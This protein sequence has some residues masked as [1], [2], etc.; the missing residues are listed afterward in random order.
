MLPLALLQLID[1]RAPTGAH[2]HSGGME[3]AVAAGLVEGAADLE[4]FC[5][6]R[7]RTAGRVAA[8]FAA[9]SAHAWR[10]DWPPARWAALD[11]EFSAR[12]PSPAVRA[13]SRAMG[14]G[15]RR[16]VIA[17]APVQATRL[18]AAWALCGPP[19]PHHPLVLG[20]AAAVCG[21]EPGDAARAAILA[22]V[23]GPA[24]AALRL[25]G[26]D[27][28]RVQA[29]TAELAPT[30]ERIADAAADEAAGAVA[31]VER[32]DDVTWLAR[33]PADSAPALDILADVHL[34][35]EVRLFAS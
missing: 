11:R 34:T 33:L 20:A 22:A 7:A 13:S 14:S 27:P 12:A 10:G 23:A 6:G 9:A 31:A 28:Y 26:L 35:Q 2:S 8:S 32:D 19:C 30:M 29:I 1:S 24:S 16:M 4:A 15:L 18:R 25:L 17:M 21:A 3:A 5:A